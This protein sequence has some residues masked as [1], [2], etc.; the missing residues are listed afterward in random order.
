MA[1]ATNSV[2]LLMVNG[3]IETVDIPE[4]NEVFLKYFFV[5]G[6]D[7]ELVSGLE[8]GS[9]QIG[10]KSIDNRQK[11]AFN[12]PLD[13]TYKS[14]SPFGWPQLVLSCYGQDVFGNDVARGYGV[15]HLPMSPGRHRIKIPLFVPEST[16][17][18]QQFLAWL[19]GRRP[20][21]VDPRVIAHGEGR[22]VTRVKSQGFV[23][24]SFNIA[25]KD[26]RKLG[27][28]TS[29]HEPPIHNST[30]AADGGAVALATLTN[31]NTINDGNSLKSKLY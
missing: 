30:N 10:H 12:F 28:T 7:W 9:S 29:S 3:C 24:L 5:F 4:Y 26:M 21:Y 13:V 15:T 22:D 8:E 2:F 19:R 11:I 16:S 14:T 20:E 1:T 17:K 23:E 27:Y 25:T 31:M 6:Q 18:L